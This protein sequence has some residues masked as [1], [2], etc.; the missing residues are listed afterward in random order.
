MLAA[1][2]VLGGHP[3]VGVWLSIGLAAAAICWMLQGWL[4]ARWALLGGILAA[5]HPAL[6]LRWGQSYWGGAVAV[7]GGA[8]VFSALGRIMRGPRICDALLM[9]L[10]L[11]VLA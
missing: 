9:G 4:P 10:G 8:L 1:G 11:A 6:F 5:L 7:I 2:Q 3:I